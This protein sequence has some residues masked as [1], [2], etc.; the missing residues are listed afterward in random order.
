MHR[1]Y[2]NASNERI[3]PSKV[4]R[5]P[6]NEIVCSIGDHIT[7]NIPVNSLVQPDQES[8]ELFFAMVTLQRISS[9]YPLGFNRCPA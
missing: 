2:C 6:S 7:T 1:V 8:L 4:E 3:P 5:G 9:C